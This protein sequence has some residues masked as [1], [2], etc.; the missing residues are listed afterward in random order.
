VCKCEEACFYSL[1]QPLSGVGKKLGKGGSF[2]HFFV[3]KY[4]TIRQTD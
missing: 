3:E 1:K 4:S 2:E